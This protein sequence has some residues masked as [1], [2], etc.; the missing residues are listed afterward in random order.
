MQYVRFQCP[1]CGAE[2][3]PELPSAEV[4]CQYCGSRFA[5]ERARTAK[6]MAGVALDPQ[7]LLAHIR[8]ASEQLAKTQQQLEVSE[9]ARAEL[10]AEQREAQA[11]QAKANKRSRRKQVAGR[12]GG[13]LIQA[14][15]LLFV[16][17]MI[18][19]TLV[20]AGV[21][22]LDDIP[23]LRRLAGLFDQIEAK[24]DAELSSEGIDPWA[25]PPMLAEV[26]G[27][28]A[29]LARVRNHD[30]D[31]MYVDAYAIPSGERLWR[32]GPLSSS[33]RELQHLRF[34]IAGHW[35]AVSDTQSSVFVHELATGHRVRTHA[36]GERVDYL[37]SVPASEP[38]ATPSVYIR[39][40]KRRHQLLD[41]ETGALTRQRQ[42]PIGCEPERANELDP[43]VALPTSV[44]AKLD[45]V[46]LERFHVDLD[47]GRGVALGHA[48]ATPDDPRG[49]VIGFGFE[50]ESPSARAKRLGRA[51]AFQLSISESA[52]RVPMPKAASPWP[53][54]STLA[55]G[56]LIIGW[57]DA[58]GGYHVDAI[59]D[60]DG[61]LAWSVALELAVGDR[62]VGV[63]A[64]AEH[65]IVIRTH[66]LELR[67]ASDGALLGSVGAATG[68]G[69]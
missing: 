42:I 52:W 68:A 27:Q 25:G 6:T 40:A 37:C 14:L 51:R 2:L 67:D 65:V 56:R 36:V 33:D 13:L 7:A 3:P 66:V 39:A 43:S 59:N 53:I 69:D 4:N 11:K 48:T 24:L 34:T 63:R 64:S 44:R 5:P 50:P 61:A 20:A 23:G 28:P 17:G 19:F 35:V 26:A 49:V 1:A 46:E 54:A 31:R 15:V 10:E 16:A 29:V 62:L 8:Q 32:I 57:S 9:V 41:L 47:T 22:A 38:G 12:I 60:K 18:V 21:L 45:A 55:V 58:D 30:D